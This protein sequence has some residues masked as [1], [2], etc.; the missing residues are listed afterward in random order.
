MKTVV[1]DLIRALLKSADWKAGGDRSEILC[2]MAAQ[3]ARLG[4]EP[5]SAFALKGYLLQVAK[6]IAGVV[7]IMQHGSK[8]VAKT[9]TI[10]PSGRVE[11]VT[12]T[13]RQEP[14]IVLACLKTLGDVYVRL[15][16]KVPAKMPALDFSIAYEGPIYSD[17]EPPKG[18]ADGNSGAGAATDKPR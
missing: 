12:E 3:L 11:S 9:T 15:A 7:R 18:G 1:E 8:T 6:D 10:G 4:L 13:V 5:D 17:E 2:E 14:A 16:S